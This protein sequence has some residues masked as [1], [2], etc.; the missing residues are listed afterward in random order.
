[1]LTRIELKNFKCFKKISVE[2][3]NLNVLAGINSMGKSSVV[4]ALLLLR[5][6]QERDQLLDGLSLN[7][8]YVQIG[9]G[10]DL[11]NRNSDGDFISILLENDKKEYLFK[12]NY[13]RDS[14]FLTIKDVLEFEDVPEQDFN[15]FRNTFAYVSADR[16]GPRRYYNSSNYE[17]FRNNQ[18]GVK[19][20][21]F[22]DYLAERSNDRI[23]DSLKHVSCS[24]N[25]LLEQTNAWLSEISPGISII[26][27][28]DSETSV[29]SLRYKDFDGDSSP[30]N[31][32]F[33]LSYVAP[34]VVALLKAKKDDLI[35]I[36]NP[37]AHLHPKGQRKMGE[38]I[39]KAAATGIQVIV[40]THSDH[41][42]NGIRLSVKQGHIKRDFVKLNYFYREKKQDTQEMNAEYKGE[43]YYE[44]K[45]CSPAILD[46]GRLSSWP[47][48]FFD[49]WD[50]ALME[51]I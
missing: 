6:S 22:A 35:I 47:D 41:L 33:G 5:Q 31:V 34:I 36:E 21:L 11:M 49:E 45:K 25:R 17:V 32:G 12:Y 27:K 38:L 2:L 28:I 24:S 16:I 14:E 9:T 23:E 15:L 43:M 8:L 37:E 48:G 39:A 3:S 18:V 46:D 42:L 40:E 10:K 26:S 7:D 29:I 13:N 44:Y 50:K 19:G 30:L 51:L 20:E 1:M 4:Q